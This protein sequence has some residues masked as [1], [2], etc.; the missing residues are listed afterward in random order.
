MFVN[1]C[2]CE[3]VYV[4]TYIFVYILLPKYSEFSNDL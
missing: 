1:V 3:Y 2:I 4:N